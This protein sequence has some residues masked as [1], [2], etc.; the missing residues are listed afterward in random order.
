MQKECLAILQK[1]D[2]KTGLC[3]DQRLEKII[4]KNKLTSWDDVDIVY[5][6]SQKE[7]LNLMKKNANLI[8]KV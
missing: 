7:W 4:I 3:D 8:Q 1:N 5:E 2:F 6:N